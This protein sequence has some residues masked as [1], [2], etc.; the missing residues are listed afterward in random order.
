MDEQETESLQC[1]AADST[2][3]ITQNGK[4]LKRRQGMERGEKL[5]PPILH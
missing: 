5:K 4:K 1:D 3:S 2:A